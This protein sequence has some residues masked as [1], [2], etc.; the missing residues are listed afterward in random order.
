MGEFQESKTFEDGSVRFELEPPPQFIDEED[1]TADVFERG[2]F[3][4]GVD[5][6]R[7]LMSD[8]PVELPEQVPLSHWLAFFQLTCENADEYDLERM[9]VSHAK[10]LLGVCA[11]HF[12]RASSGS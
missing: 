9:P 1:I 5:P 10:V 4:L 6:D 12:R 8:E 11:D 7:W 3:L 2:C